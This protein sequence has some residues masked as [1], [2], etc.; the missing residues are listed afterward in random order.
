MILDRF[1]VPKEKRFSE[2]AVITL[3]NQSIFQFGNALS[4]IFIN[5]YL[6]RLTNSLLINGLFNLTAILSQGVMTIFLGKVAK[7]RDRLTMYRYGIFLTAFFYLCIVV[8]QEWM[9]DYFYL[10][11]LLKGISQAAYWIGYFTLVYDVSNN[12]NR[13]RYLGWNQ[14]SMSGA[15]LLGPAMA[16]FIIS[17]YTEL[18]GYIMVFSFA[19]IMFLVAAMGSLRMKKETTHHKAY[20]M[21]FLPL[22]LTKKPGFGLVLLGWFIIGFPQ[23]VLMYIPHIL[24]YDIFPD[25][26]FVGY[27]NMLFLMLSILASYVISRFARLNATKTYLFVAAFGMTFSTVF[28]LWDISIW[29]VVLFMS[30]GSIFKPLQANTYAAHYYRWLDHLPLKENFRVESV[31]LRESIINIGRGLGIVIFMIFSAEI[32][33]TTIPWVIVSLMA[34][35]LL[36]PWMAKES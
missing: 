17:L 36:I 35:Q 20:Y 26:S 25:E 11:A 15:N 10:F 12:E 13:H 24:L 31:V 32:N 9:V 3:M 2:Q 27:M 19:F 29:T 21:K 16:G 28:L 7:R 5:L 1:K 30:I 23:G 18:T 14:I 6:W 34:V 22:L 33:P 4:M 8:T